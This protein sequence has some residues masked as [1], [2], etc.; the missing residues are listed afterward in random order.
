MKLSKFIHLMSLIVGVV[1]A[2]ALVGAW[3]AGENETVLGL[4]Q[5]HLFY[6]AIVL[7]LI[8]IAASV[9][10]LVRLELEAAHPGTSPLI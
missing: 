3:A 7:E 6:D 4:T 10:T 5:T 9:C 1:G 8:A 2:L